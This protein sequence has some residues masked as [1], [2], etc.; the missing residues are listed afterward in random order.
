MTTSP[1]TKI[2][3]KVKTD[4]NTIYHTTKSEAVYLGDHKI[5]YHRGSSS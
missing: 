4:K 1:K 3:I 2:K 5:A